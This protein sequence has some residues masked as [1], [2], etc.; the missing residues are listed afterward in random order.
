MNEY[1]AC[2][3]TFYF[4]FHWSDVAAQLCE[5]IRRAL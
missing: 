5:A 1:V 2:E 3:L 4:C